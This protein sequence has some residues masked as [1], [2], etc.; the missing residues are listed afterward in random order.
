[1]K[2]KDVAKKEKEAKVS[3]S[4]GPMDMKKDMKKKGSKG[5]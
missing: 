4:K 5:C 1:M 3:K 2:K